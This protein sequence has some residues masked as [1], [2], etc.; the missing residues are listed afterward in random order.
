VITGS[1]IQRAIEGGL[2]LDQLNLHGGDE[3]V[4]GGGGGRGGGSPGGGGNWR[5]VLW[6]VQAAISLTFLLTRIF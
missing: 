5:N 1:E 3:L 4:F 6:P 2:S